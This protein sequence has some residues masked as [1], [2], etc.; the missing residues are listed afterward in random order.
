[1]PRVYRRLRR[2]TAQALPNHHRRADCLTSAR[3]GGPAGRGRGGS[4]I[5]GG[6]VMGSMHAALALSAGYLP[7]RPRTRR[8]TSGAGRCRSGQVPG[9]AGRRG[10]TPRHEDARTS[11]SAWQSRRAAGTAAAT[12][13][14]SNRIESPTGPPHE[15]AG[16]VRDPSAAV[17]RPVQA[18]QAD[19]SATA[20]NT[21]RR[22]RTAAGG[23][24][25]RGPHA[26]QALDQD[27]GASCRAG[28]SVRT[29]PDQQSG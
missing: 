14:A 4:P 28:A 11:T 25:A 21:R 18:V 6:L 8:M 29:P 1:M 19:A 15:R 22:G 24:S 9:R 7:G 16:L 20:R 23:Q 27:R 2:V 5:R 26:E 3:V 17:T 10:R 13:A 12:A